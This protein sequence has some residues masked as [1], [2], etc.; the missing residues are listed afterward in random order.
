LFR[1]HEE[2]KTKKKTAINWDPH[3]TERYQTR[4]NA[5]NAKTRTKGK[6]KKHEASSKRRKTRHK[7]SNSHKQTRS[8]RSGLLANTTTNAQERRKKMEKK[9]GR[10]NFKK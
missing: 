3:T 6:K 1:E 7:Q 8:G 10:R 9:I 2:K 4:L 5:T